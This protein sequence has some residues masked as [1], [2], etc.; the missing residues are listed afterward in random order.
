MQDVGR[1]LTTDGRRLNKIKKKEFGGLWERGLTQMDADETQ[2]QE[3][4]VDG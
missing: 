4:E 2:I 3:K 1:E